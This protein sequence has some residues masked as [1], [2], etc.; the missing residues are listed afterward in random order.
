L[1]L[2]DGEFV[3]YG[4]GSGF[5]PSAPAN[6]LIIT[7]NNQTK[8]SGT[9]FTFNGTQLTKSGLQS[10]DTVVIADFSSAGAP[11]A[12]SDVVYPI[13]V[14]NAQI[15]YGGGHTG[16]K[17]Y[18]LY[19][20]GKM[21]VSPTTIQFVQENSSSATTPSI[22]F[23]S[24][25]SSGNLLLASIIYDVAGSPGTCTDNLG[26]TYSLAVNVDD[27]DNETSQ[28][29]FWCVSGSSG[30]CTVTAA[31]AVKGMAVFEFHNVAQTSTLDGTNSNAQTYSSSS[32]PQDWTTQ[33]VPV[34]HPGDLVF[35]NYIVNNNTGF[36]I[37][38]QSW[39]DPFQLSFLSSTAVA[40]TGTVTFAS[41][42][43]SAT[44]IIASFK[45]G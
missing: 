1:N 16:P 21:T 10:G 31:N 19:V 2:V 9:K 43:G 41:G 22:G 27:P 17:Y 12:A 26:N 33:T 29:L 7:A 15:S 30:S 35:T 14:G 3:I 42:A 23:N 18:I 5:A 45:A 37:N 44:Y 13:Q 38:S 32:S 25:V 24:N 11:A 4:Q 40:V 34:N 39:I 20:P 8:K 36:T 6:L 28:A